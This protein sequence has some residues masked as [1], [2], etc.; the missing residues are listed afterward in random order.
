MI[1]DG[2]TPQDLDQLATIRYRTGV[3]EVEGTSFILIDNDQ[4]ARRISDHAF[5]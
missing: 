3:P 4:Q 5:V 2:D 1:R